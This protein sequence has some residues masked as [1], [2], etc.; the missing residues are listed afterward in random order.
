M[1]G[2][3]GEGLSMIIAFLAIAM[4]LLTVLILFY[5]PTEASGLPHA[6]SQAFIGV[7]SRG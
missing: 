1:R 4:I 3:V 2:W 5:A 6:I 7:F